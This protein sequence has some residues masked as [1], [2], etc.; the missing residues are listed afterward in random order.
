MGAILIASVLQ[1]ASKYFLSNFLYFPS[2]TFASAS[3]SVIVH[4][5]SSSDLPEC[6]QM[7]AFHLKLKL[8]DGVPQ[9]AVMEHFLH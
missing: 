4:S 5:S 1:L 2:L 6:E 3:S 7:V 8:L 9:F